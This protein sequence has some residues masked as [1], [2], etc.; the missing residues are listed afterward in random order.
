MAFKQYA[1]VSAILL[2]PSCISIR[3][4]QRKDQKEATGTIL[5]HAF[6]IS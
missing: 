3:M 2:L 4:W 6:D 1:E 5:A